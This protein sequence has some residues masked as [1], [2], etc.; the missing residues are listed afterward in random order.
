MNMNVYHI[1]DNDLDGVSALYLSELTFPKENLKVIRSRTRTIDKMVKEFVENKW[2]KNT[3]FVITDLSIDS[4][5]LAELIDQKVKEGYQM[6]LIDHHPTAFWLNEYSWATVVNEENGVKTSATSM[7]FDYLKEH[8]GL[9]VTDLLAD[10]VELVRQYDTWDWFNVGLIVNGEKVPNERSK[11]LNDLLYIVGKDRFR[12][13]VLEKL[14]NDPDYESFSF[15]EKE[16]YILDVEQYRIEEYIASKEK[17]MK[18]T[19]FTLD[20]RSYQVGLIIGENYHSELGNAIC[21]EHPEIDFVVIMDVGRHKISFRATK[22]DVDVSVVA[23]HFGGGGHAPTAGCP[24]NENSIPVFL[25]PLLPKSKSEE[26]IEKLTFDL[27]QQKLIGN[28]KTVS[29]DY[30]LHSLESEEY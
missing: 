2:D 26:K 8:H 24:L 17:Q 27:S 11:R 7:Y 29:I 9:D 18:T 12:E 19:E 30:V 10:Y 22:T 6:K 3:L 25:Q 13:S 20:E 16:E 1:S 28:Q 4:Q 5:E 23:K 14:Q 15:T 21:R